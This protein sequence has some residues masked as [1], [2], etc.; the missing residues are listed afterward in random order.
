MARSCSGA[1]A[2]RQDQ[3]VADFA[4][5]VQQWVGRALS[6]F[7]SAQ[8]TYNSYE[9]QNFQI[10]NPPPAVLKNVN[11]SNGRGSN[12]NVRGFKSRT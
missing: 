7:R 3:W 4:Y 8:L 6:G 12:L 9:L 11:I 1:V 5:V 10:P 2:E